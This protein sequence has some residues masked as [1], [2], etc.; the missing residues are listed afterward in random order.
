MEKN[1]PKGKVLISYSE[2]GLYYDEQIA[3][4]E[5]IEAVTSSLESKYQL[6]VIIN[7]LNQYIT[8][9]PPFSLRP[10]LENETDYKLLSD[11]RISTPGRPEVIITD[12]FSFDLDPFNDRSWRFWFLNL[13]WLKEHL[14]SLEDK[15]RSKQFEIIFLKWMEFIEDEGIDVEFLY[16]DHSLALRGNNLIDCIIFCPDHLK[17][18]VFNHVMDI[19]YLL[20]SP[21]E[22]NALSNHA[23]D[24]AIT[25][26][27]ITQLFKGKRNIRAIREISINRIIRELEYS[28]V[29][30]VHVENSPAYHHGMI[31]NMHNSL[32]NLLQ[33]PS[34]SRLKSKQQDLSK[35]IPFLRW[36]VRADG[37]YPPIGDTEQREVNFELVQEIFPDQFKISNQG[38]EVFANGYA[39]WRSENTHLT[40]KSTQ[41]GRFHRHDDDCSLTL[42]HNGDDILLDSGLL[43]YMEKDSARIHVRSASAHSGIEIPGFK[44]IRNIFD[45]SAKNARVSKTGDHSSFAIMGMYEDFEI[46]RKVVKEGN[47]IRITDIF[48]ELSIINNVRQNFIIT[49]DWKLDKQKDKIVFSKKNGKSWSLSCMNLDNHLEVEVVETFV[50]KM[51]NKKSGARRISFYPQINQIEMIITLDYKES[52]AGN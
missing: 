27:R 33:Y 49:D 47:I 6:S 12:I 38:L 14:S 24:Q 48:C 3:P 37:K 34:N 29:D 20:T 9:N 44:A 28:F 1:P 7:K 31:K 45:S 26:N 19:G 39:V 42:W 8:E 23:F 22:D 25:L 13:S 21:L 11:I 35:M 36:I 43:Y 10:R 15:F 4:L 17:S 18:E 2:N 30:G 32:K 5:V 46:S 51:K 50:S 40:M 16:H 52:E 41:I